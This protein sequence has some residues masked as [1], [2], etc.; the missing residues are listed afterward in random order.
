MSTRKVDE[1]VPS[2]GLS[3]IDKRAVARSCK[4]LDEGVEAFGNRPLEYAYSYVWL[5]LLWF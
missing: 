1:R 3:G 2:L 5:D 4:Q